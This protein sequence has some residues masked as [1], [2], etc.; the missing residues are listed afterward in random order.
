MFSLVSLSK[1]KFF[2]RVAIVS[3][4][5]HSYCSCRTHVALVSL[6]LQNR[7]D[8]IPISIKLR[9]MIPSVLIITTR[10]EHVYYLLLERQFNFCV[11]F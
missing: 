8:P 10:Y 5:S 6:V 4:V 2:T 11:V 9:Q 1:S 3:F 7:L